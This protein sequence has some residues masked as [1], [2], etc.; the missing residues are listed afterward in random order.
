M[1]K[2]F[3]SW[4]KVEELVGLLEMQVRQFS[5]NE[6]IDFSYIMGIPRG[7]LIPA[8]MLSHR[9]GIPLAP[10]TIANEANI[11]VVD[12][13]ADTGSTLSSILYKAGSWSTR[14]RVTT[15]YHRTTSEVVPVFAGERINHLDWIVFPWET[16]ES[17]KYDKAQSRQ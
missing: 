5:L 4:K 11:L 14:M 10:P 15:L 3:V 9:L 6:G 7:G 8:V 12:D 16:E 1:N 13:I 2:Y 17:S